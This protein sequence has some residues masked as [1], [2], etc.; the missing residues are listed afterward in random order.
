[1]AAMSIWLNRLAPDFT[2]PNA[3]GGERISLSSF[4]GHIVIVSFWSAECPW[5]RRA[6]VL[7][8]YR[9]LTWKAQGVRAVGVD[10]NVVE[11]EAQ[12]RHEIDYRLLSYPIGL[13]VGHRVADLYRAET[14]PHLFVVDREGLVRYAGAPDDATAEAREPRVIYLD[15]AVSALLADRR[16][17]PALTPAYGC[18]IVREPGMATNMPVS[19]APRR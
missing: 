13:D 19:I 4:R 3:V 1:M 17:E 9:L 6:D 7:L 15:Q 10:S 5:S 11:P 8:V 16:P 14:T 18:P 12:I 2:L